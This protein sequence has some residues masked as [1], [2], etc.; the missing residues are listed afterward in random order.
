MLAGRPSKTPLKSRRFNNG[1]LADPKD[2]NKIEY[3]IKDYLKNNDL[4]E[5]NVN[6]L[7]D[8]L[9]ATLRGVLIEIKTKI[10]KGYN[11]ELIKL[12]QEIKQLEISHGNSLNNNTL[13]QLTQ[14][15]YEYNNILSERAGVWINKF[16]SLNLC[17]ANKAGK[18]LTSYLKHKQNQH[19]IT[20]I[21]DMN[22][23]T[24]TNPKELLNCFKKNY[25]S[26]YRT[27]QNFDPQKCT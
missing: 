6:T 2:K 18:M 17:E 16:K 23:Q 4:P 20:S 12:E 9:K 14:K 19:R 3:S 15:K 8:A 24:H 5:T 25:V 11:A 26:L 10:N 7:W 13:N 22:N 21:K 27:D 1:I